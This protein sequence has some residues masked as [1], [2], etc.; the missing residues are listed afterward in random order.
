VSGVPSRPYGDGRVAGTSPIAGIQG[1]IMSSI[2]AITR[3]WT[4]QVRST[5]AQGKPC[6]L[7]WRNLMLTRQ[8]SKPDPSQP[9]AIATSVGINCKATFFHRV[10]PLRSQIPGPFNTH[11]PRIVERFSPIHF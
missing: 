10:I 1:H 11:S 7:L 2:V 8:S 6:P 3:S 4:P 9:V 5:D